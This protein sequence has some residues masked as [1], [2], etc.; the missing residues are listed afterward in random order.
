MKI[1]DN[2]KYY[3]ILME[4]FS[5]DERALDRDVSSEFKDFMLKEQGRVYSTTDEIRH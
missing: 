4:H 3:K 1:D 5:I 2:E